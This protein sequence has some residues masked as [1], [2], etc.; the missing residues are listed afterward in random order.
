M[1]FIALELSNKEIK[2]LSSD[3]WYHSTRLTAW[4]SFCN[5]GV[6]AEYN[7]DTSD[8]CDFGYGFYLTPS[9][10]RA[11]EYLARLLGAGIISAGEAAVILG[12]RF[13]ALDLFQT[14]KYKIKTFPAYDVD[15]ATFIFENRLNNVAGVYQ[16]TYDAIY[17]VM[18]DSTPTELMLSYKSGACTREHV[19]TEIATH[20]T[21][22]KQ[23]SLHN[24]EICDT[25]V[26][27]EAY[28]VKNSERKELNIDDYTE[29]RKI[30]CHR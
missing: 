1:G 11:E 12:F 29:K 20:G 24:Q 4:E 26:L 10:K 22:V 21:S 14:E 2:A 5:N 15:F 19:I 18:S 8:S 30:L 16:H 28:T 7:K 23:L 9:R 6:L 27:S 13:N 3:I 25:L 17:G